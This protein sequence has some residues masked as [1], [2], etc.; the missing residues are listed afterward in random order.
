MDLDAGTW[1]IGN[2]RHKTG[3]EFV[4]PLSSAALALVKSQPSEGDYVFKVNRRSVSRL[5]E[6]MGYGGEATVHGFR[7]S[8]RDWAGDKTNH[9]REVIEACM[10]HQ[11]KDKAEAA[12]RRSDALEKRRKLMIRR[13]TVPLLCGKVVARM[14]IRRGPRGDGRPRVFKATHPAKPRGPHQWWLHQLDELEKKAGDKG[15][16]LQAIY[17]V[18]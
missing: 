3:K 6:G 10:S 17:C 7:S 1:T 15:T 5:L 16:V 4:V 11:V 12:Y 13:N 18:R 14:A 8:F 9:P 2:G